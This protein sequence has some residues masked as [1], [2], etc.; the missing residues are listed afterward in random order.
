MN[1]FLMLLVLT[2]TGQAIYAQYVYTIKADS[3]K[4]TN[5]CD[6]AELIIENHTQNVPGFLYNKGK[7]RTEFRRGVFAINDSL[8]LI[9]GDT[10]NLY[11]GRV[12]V[13]ASN[14]LHANDGHVKMGGELVDIETDLKFRFTDEELFTA[15]WFRVKSHDDNSFFQIQENYEGQ[16]PNGQEYNP[17]SLVFHSW[18]PSS[19]ASFGCDHTGFSVSAGA[20]GNMNKALRFDTVALQVIN[21]RMTVG[22]PGGGPHYSLGTATLHIAAGTSAPGTAPLKF[23]PGPLLTTI[24]NNAVEY[25]GNDLYL[26]QGSIRYKLAKMLDGQLTTNFGGPSLGAFN[27]VTTSLTVTGAKPGDVVNVSANSGAVNPPS[28]IVTAYVTSNN[29]VTLQAYNASNSAVTI[30]ADTYKVRVIK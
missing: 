22:F 6:T 23:A 20:P 11:K 5:T 18:T 14:G 12:N 27:S 9:G 1:R 28:I 21:G 16:D 4:I 2:C 7:G 3:V 26:T 25:D 10:M 24:E 17:T 15:K 8:Y 29:T 30:A 19:H 13:T